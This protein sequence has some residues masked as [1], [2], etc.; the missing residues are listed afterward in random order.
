M[1]P[2]AGLRIGTPRRVVVSRHTVAP[3]RVSQSAVIEAD[4][5][6][7][8]CPSSR[9]RHSSASTRLLHPRAGDHETVE[10][11]RPLELSPSLLP[12]FGATVRSELGPNRARHGTT[13]I[14]PPRNRTP[15]SDARDQTPAIRRPRSDARDQTPAIRRPRSD[16][17]DQTPAIR[18]PR[19]DARDRTP[20]IGRPGL[21]LSLGHTGRAALEG[22][23]DQLPFRT[24]SASRSG[25][26][27]GAGALLL[28]ITPRTL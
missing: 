16:A 18:R 6:A 21:R 13:A 19:S 23:H 3:T 7:P 27:A 20:A 15:G 8:A 4:G 17:R 26:G 25:A 5:L 2:A 14:P 9:W 24:A 12:H 28:P 22:Q 1:A 11:R 10:C